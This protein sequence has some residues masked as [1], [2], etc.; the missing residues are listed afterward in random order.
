MLNI[1]VPSERSMSQIYSAAI[2]KPTF[3]ELFFVRRQKK[4]AFFQCSMRLI[5]IS[6]HRFVSIAVVLPVC[7]IVFFS[8]FFFI[9]LYPLFLLSIIFSDH[10]M[11]GQTNGYLFVLGSETVEALMRLFIRIQ[12]FSHWDYL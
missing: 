3:L 9:S 4:L 7:L 10:Q 11:N 12:I 6:W 1:A 5:F 8:F 2:S